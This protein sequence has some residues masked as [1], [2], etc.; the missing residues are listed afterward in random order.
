MA[1][2]APVHPHV[3]GDSRVA[4]VDQDAQAGSPPRAWGQLNDYYYYYYY[5]YRFTPTCVG[6]A[7][8]RGIVHISSPVHP[9]V[10][11]D[12]PGRELLWLASSGSPPRAWG[13]LDEPGVDP[14]V[15]RFTP[16]CVGT[17]LFP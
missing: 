4:L 3:R 9:H 12:S 6:T 10:R 17:A 14:Q 7:L 11:G 8:T 13:Q 1:R 2:K 5:Y 15:D 16:T